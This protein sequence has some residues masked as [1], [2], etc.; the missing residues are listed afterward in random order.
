[1]MP[2]G[3]LFIPAPMGESFAARTRR[4][5]VGGSKAAHGELDG[6]VG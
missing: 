5:W 4:G 3:A 1:M 6:T 2:I